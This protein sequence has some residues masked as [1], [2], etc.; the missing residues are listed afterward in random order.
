[1]DSI[2]LAFA[3]YWRNS[4][5]D[6]TFGKGAFKKD[7]R[8]IFSYWNTSDIATG[9][10]DDNTVQNFFSSE[11]KDVKCVNVI[12]RPQVFLRRILHGKE[13]TSGAPQIITPLVTTAVL[14]RDGYLYPTPATIIPRDLLEPLSQGTFSI[15]NISQFDTYTTTKD[16]FSIDYDEDEKIKNNSS[17]EERKAK[18]IHFQEQWRKYLNDCDHLLKAVVGNWLKEH[19]Q[20]EKA[21]YGFIQKKTQIDGANKHIIRLYDHLIKNKRITPLFT[22]FAYN[23]TKPVEPLLP[24][25]AKFT[26]RLGHSGD[27]FP[28]AEA[29]RDA[30]NHF[31]NSEHGEI[32]AV[33]GPPGTGKTTLVL[34]V[35]ATLW[36]KAAL[37]K[38]EPPIIIAT[39][40]N[41]QAVTNII[42]AFGKDF[43]QGFGPLA[44]R[45]LPTVKSFGAY[46]P[47]K[48][49][50]DEANQK[51]QTHTF[52]NR[53]ESK[54]FIEDA[55]KDYLSSA[56]KAFPEQEHISVEKIVDLLHQQLQNEIRKL[57]SIQQSWQALCHARTKLSQFVGINVGN[58]IR[59]KQISLSSLNQTIDTLKHLRKKWLEF[60]ANEPLIYSFFSW[61]SVIRNKRYLRIKIFLENESGTELPKIIWSKIDEI[62]EYIDEI[63]LKK[64]R[65]SNTHQQD[66]KLAQEIIQREKQ[67]AR[68]WKKI[69]QS[70][71]HTDNIE[72]NFAQADELADTQIR[73]KIFLITTHYW[74]GRW[75]LDMFNIKNIK[76]EKKKTGRQTSEPRWRR[77]MK[78]TPCIV[79]TNFML[80]ANM[81]V[82]QYISHNKYDD[83][84]LYDF[85]DLLIV[86]EAGQ[87]L[88]EV[89]AASFSLAK[90]ALVIGDTEQIAPI[91]N[92]PVH[93]DVG[94]VLSEKIITAQDTKQC[95]EYYAK[96]TDSGKTAAAG[97]VMKIAQ[98]A[99]RYQYDPGMAR[100]M[101]LYEHR[102]CIDDIINYC[103]NLCYHGKLIPKRGAATSNNLFP[104]MGYL[105]IDGKGVM[106]NGGSRYNRLEA[107]TIAAWIAKNKSTIE[108]HYQKKLHEI[109]GVITPF[110]AQ[111]LAI[112]R[113]FKQHEL[114]Q[115]EITVGTV[116]SLQGAE[117]HIV[118]F[119]SVYSKHEDG[120]FIDLNNSMLNVAVSRAK[121][122]FLVFGDMDLFELQP[123]S[124]PRG[125]LAK[126]LFA[127]TSNAL[128][129]EYKQ[130]DDL[131]KDTIIYALHGV[132]QH[133]DFLK[134]IFEQVKNTV[135]VV[136]PWLSYQK[137]EEL[138]LLQAMSQ[139]KQRG[140]QITVV[141]DKEF[142]IN[143]QDREK[144]YERQQ[145]LESAI[146]NLES[147]GITTKLVKRVHSKIVI[148][149]MSLLCVGSFNWF[150]ATRDANYERYDTS[151]VY[152]GENLKNEILT[153]GNSL[154]QR[155]CK[156]F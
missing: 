101:Y 76:E 26:E 122:S 106:A 5:A 131:T 155:Q 80:P 17:E 102:R 19:E 28:L 43:S 25:N 71:G 40:T 153:I 91:W 108:N 73:F 81:T 138:G 85:A 133:D 41:N 88:P 35:I 83:D 47:A 120:T 60:Q 30:L 110:S 87:V 31:L 146:S 150:S 34:S 96:L 79:M 16:I 61:I 7:D 125:L 154:E 46:F 121:D 65:E 100:G 149:D 127:N 111:V 4:L 89:A 29:Q 10:L 23:D 119:S 62:T 38:S 78:V 66:L 6:A 13:R 56:S 93:V 143:P 39:S 9:R 147:L 57:S 84:Y 140:V 139:A 45:W 97:S 59:Q 69:T 145:M 113:A 117:R 123:Q 92:I 112:K 109:I 75:L 132:K 136:S 116:H 68:D 90:K 103:N 105:H 3:S 135:T 124:E 95:Q 36:A 126:Y 11:Q 67:A 1:M 21:Q 156:L 137:L 74:E 58:Y 134:E 55:E 144:R 37:D 49:K 107:E 27:K 82:K 114:T 53:I 44:G 48:S 148:G 14:S 99:T 130:R 15:G 52:F 115:D 70:L 63:C 128:Q 2:S 77:R 50:E 32:L 42:E 20:Y 104:A 64:Q 51:Y 18:S 8:E 151:L 152:R 94:N 142:N 24:S 12:L 118:I 129:F 86:D 22:R 54:E 141:T 98:Q 33:N 72:L